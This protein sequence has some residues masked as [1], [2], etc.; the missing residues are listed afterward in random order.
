MGA[1]VGSR[2]PTEG[3]EYECGTCIPHGILG[4][5][6]ITTIATIG[7]PLLA[8]VCPLTELESF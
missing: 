8:A 4:T 3:G 1:P 5:F 6:S 2:R 7:E